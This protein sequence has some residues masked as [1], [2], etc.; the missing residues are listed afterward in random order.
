MHRLG[1]RQIS[2]STFRPVVN[3]QKKTQQGGNA[4]FVPEF[5]LRNCVFERV[6]RFRPGKVVGVA[7]ENECDGTT[8]QNIIDV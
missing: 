7:A 2:V 8:P 6:G 3:L 4:V 5:N 1:F